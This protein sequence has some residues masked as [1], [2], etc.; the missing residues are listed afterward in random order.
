MIIDDLLKQDRFSR[1]LQKA[2]ARIITQKDT[3]AVTTA[4]ALLAVIDELRQTNSLL[5]ELV[6]QGSFEGKVERPEP[7]KVRSA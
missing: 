6:T 2:T 5:K 1:E 4:H 3:L 7:K